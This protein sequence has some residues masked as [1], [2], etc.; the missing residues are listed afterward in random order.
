M[1]MQF[2]DFSKVVKIENF[3]QILFT[4]LIFAQNME[5]GYTLEPSPRGAAV[6]TNT[7][8]LCFGAKIRKLGIPLYT[9]VL[10][11]E[12]RDPSEYTLH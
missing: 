7:H 1:P 12:K 2:T 10:L 6:L 3:L 9:P 5:C 4:F 11:L 8:D